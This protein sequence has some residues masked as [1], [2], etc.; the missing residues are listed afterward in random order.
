MNGTTVSTFNAS[1]M[2]PAR[3]S[4]VPTTPISVPWMMK[5]RVMLEGAAPSVR[6]IAMSACLSV[7]TI[8]RLDT[9][10]NA[11]T[12][13]MRMITMNII[14]FSICTARKKLACCWVQSLA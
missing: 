13:M 12:A 5:I 2:P 10:L 4:S 9:M 3:P 7:T 8:T 14:R 6:R 1:A 11:A